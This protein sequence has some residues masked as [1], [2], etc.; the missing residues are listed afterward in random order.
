MHVGESNAVH[1]WVLIKPYYD[2]TATFTNQIYTSVPANSANSE[3]RIYL[4]NESN[5]VFGTIGGEQKYTYTI[6][7]KLVGNTA[8]SSNF[9]MRLEIGTS[10]NTK[11]LPIPVSSDVTCISNIEAADNE[12]L[13]SLSYGT[14]T[15]PETVKFTFKSSTNLCEEDCW[16]NFYLK[17]IWAVAGLAID[18]FVL[19]ATC[20]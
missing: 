5:T 17:N 3:A 20:P 18:D 9:K 13:Y 1:D 11:N 7:F 10:S 14:I 6:S 8:S 16:V 2:A 12:E 4:N 15:N 19:V